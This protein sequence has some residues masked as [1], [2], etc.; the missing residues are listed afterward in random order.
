MRLLFANPVTYAYCVL[1]VL[2]YKR[3]TN[4]GYSQ[5]VSWIRKN[6][7]PHKEKV[8]YLV[9]KCPLLTIQGPPLNKRL[10]VLTTL[11]YLQYTFPFL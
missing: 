11:F 9:M 10:T 3:T 1:A 4:S 8:H 6:H 5:G 7:P 2:N